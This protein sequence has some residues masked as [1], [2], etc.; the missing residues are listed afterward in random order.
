MQR[1]GPVRKFEHQVSPD[2]FY[3]VDLDLLVDRKPFRYRF[4]FDSHR[5]LY[6]FAPEN[7]TLYGRTQAIGIDNVKSSAERLRCVSAVSNLEGLRLWKWYG[8]PCIQ[9]AG[10][11]YLVTYSSIPPAKAKTEE[12]LDP[13]ISF[14]VTPKGTI[15]VMFPGS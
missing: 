14:L 1:T 13:F 15:S 8:D 5:R 3:F 12:Y 2:P 9:K 4:Y 11:D 7:F 10:D 6:R